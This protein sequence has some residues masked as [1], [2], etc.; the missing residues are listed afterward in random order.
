MRLEVDGKAA[1]AATGSASHAPGRRAVVFIHG[2]GMDHSVWVMPARHFAR[3]GM[4]V[5][6][7]DLPGHGRSQG[8]GLDSIA[9]MA[10]WVVRAMDAAHFE[11]AAVVGHSMGS[12][13]AYVLAARHP[14]RCRAL[15]LLGASAPMPVTDALLDAARDND[16]AAIDM[17]NTWS[18]SPRAKLGASPNPGM[19][20]LGGGERLLETAAPGVF[21]ADLAACNGFDPEAD[22]G[23]VRCPA[24]VVVGEADQMT[25]A[26]AGIRVSE[27]MRDAQVERLA[28]CGH[29]MLS[30]QPN[31]VLDALTAIVP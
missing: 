4:N 16:H 1:F 28:G 23:P 7:L 2:A 21:H 18:H 22:A 17:A 5:L 6:A 9:A 19:W 3:T 26:R 10:D 15:A 12:L 30:E 8:P 25:P 14:G 27:R 11:A 13:V 20:M 24:L 31:A 29:A